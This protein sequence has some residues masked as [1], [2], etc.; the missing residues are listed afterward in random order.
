MLSACG[1]ISGLGLMAEVFQSHE[2]GGGMILDESPGMLEEGEDS[3]L[4][5]S[6]KEGPVGSLRFFCPSPG[7]RDGEASD[8]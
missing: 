6:N 7:E 1:V 8:A 4:M 5:V 2:R 3:I